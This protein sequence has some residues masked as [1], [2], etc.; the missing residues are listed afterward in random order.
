MRK[1]SLRVSLFFRFFLF[2]LQLVIH[3]LPS[4][5]GNEDGP[6]LSGGVWYITS[7]SFFYLTICA[8]FNRRTFCSARFPN[9]YINLALERWWTKQSRKPHEWVLKEYTDE[10]E[11]VMNG[12]HLA[13]LNRYNTNFLCEILVVRLF[14][15]NLDH[16][17]SKIS[18]AHLNRYFDVACEQILIFCWLVFLVYLSL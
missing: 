14:W 8:G 5:D 18:S 15:D 13:S 3:L 4:A 12:K 10:R 6:Y 16:F 7:F 2:L 1:S 11:R 17:L 9:D